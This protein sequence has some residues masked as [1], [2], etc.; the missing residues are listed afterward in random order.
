MFTFYHPELMLLASSS[1][2]PTSTPNNRVR[3]ALGVLIRLML[4]LTHGVARGW[5]GLRGLS[6]LALLRKV[7]ESHGL[8]TTLFAVAANTV[9]MSLSSVQ[10]R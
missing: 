6:V 4:P 5:K 2:T 9:S 8:L 3:V 10:G 1:S 7:R